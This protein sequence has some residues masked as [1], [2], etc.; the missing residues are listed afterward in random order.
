MTEQI[1]APQAAAPAHAP[2]GRRLMTGSSWMV[3]MRFAVRGIG[4]ISTMVLA[5]VLVPADFGVMAMA[6][7]LI[8][9]IE[10]FTDSG[11]TLA[12]IRHPNPE[13]AHYDTAW[14]I[15]VLINTGLTAMALALAPFAPLYFHDDRIVPVIQLLSLRIFLGGFVNI[16][17][18]DFRRNLDFAREFWFGV[19]RK[20]L[21]FGVTLTLALTWRSYWALAAGVV[22]GHVLE[23]T[24]SYIMSPYRPRFNVSKMRELWG[25]SAWL[26]TMELGRFFEGRVDEWVVA[27][28]AP[29]AAVGSY[30]I[31]TEF[32]AL[33]VTE[34]LDPVAR[35]LFP[36]YARLAADPHELKN[37]YLHVLAASTAVAA[38]AGIGL[39]LV[40]PDLVSVMLGPKWTGTAPLIIWFAPAA[41]ITGVC[42]T[43]FPVMNAAGESRLSAIQTWLRVFF[44]VPSMI[45]AA[46]TGVLVNFA[47]A[48]LVVSIVL[49]PTFFARLRKIL[50]I[51]W[52]DMISATWRPVVA[53]AIMA[54]AVLALDDTVSSVAI[55]VL[56]LSANV[57]VGASVFVASQMALWAVTGGPEGLERSLLHAMRRALRPA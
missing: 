26:L 28:V 30:T 5:R 1:V 11:Q 9:V 32:G 19:T 43:V 38:A 16:G 18:I 37:A 34:V 35:A 33:P 20:L 52:R 36:N 17:T 29:P 51:S 3:G 8:S 6:M 13:R 39:A 49:I 12:V 55:P 21:T 40:A 31:G 22:V 27:G 10:V 41:A 42:N 24:L 44:F 14:T 45:W 4:L 23:V 47:I 15:G 54:L 7:L 48:K 25:Y 2:L 50:P 46:S 56:R 53:A 57:M